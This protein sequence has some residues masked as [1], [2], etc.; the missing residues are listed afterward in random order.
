MHKFYIILL[1]IS[2]SSCKSQTTEWKKYDG[3][4]FSIS[5]PSNWERTKNLTEDTFIFKSIKESSSDKFQENFN[6]IIQDLSSQKMSLE[7]YSKLTY[8]QV[9]QAVGENYISQYKNVSLSN[10]EAKEMSYILPSNPERNQFMNLKVWQKW[11]IKDDRAYVLTFT[12]QK[13]KFDNYVKIAEEMF[14]SFI[15]K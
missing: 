6:V 13:E 10:Q 2:F 1:V 12:A 15:V 3:K 14:T 7:D 4:A 8:N 9:K 5:S 11:I